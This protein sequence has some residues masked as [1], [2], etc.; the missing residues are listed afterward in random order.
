MFSEEGSRLEPIS[1]SLPDQ[2][3]SMGTHGIRHV[4]RLD[5]CKGEKICL[6]GSRSNLRSGGYSQPVMGNDSIPVVSGPAVA[7]DPQSGCK[8]PSGVAKRGTLFQSVLIVPFWK[9]ALW[10]PCLSGMKLE[11]MTLPKGAIC[12]FIPLRQ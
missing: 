3:N 11:I 8:D 12:S 4:R 1:G 10:Y 5:E 2:H 6:M 9:G 7:V